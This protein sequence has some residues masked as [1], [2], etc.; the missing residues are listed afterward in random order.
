MKKTLTL[1]AG[2]LLAFVPAGA[3]S[4]GEL[5]VPGGNAW[6]N[7][8]HSSGGGNPHSA[9]EPERPG[10]GN[11]G[12]VALGSKTGGCLA[13]VTSS[14]LEVVEGEFEEP[15]TEPTEPTDGFSK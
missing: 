3:A 6:G 14:G 10:R 5:G 12:F 9:L 2:L 7:C 13:P 8:K 4:A 1:T 11:G 15:A